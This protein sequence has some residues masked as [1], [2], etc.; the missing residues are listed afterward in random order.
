MP[1][2]RSSDEWRQV[3]AE[4]ED[5]ERRS[6]P[7]VMV[8]RKPRKLRPNGWCL[9]EQCRGWIPYSAGAIQRRYLDREPE[10]DGEGFWE[11]EDEPLPDADWVYLKCAWCGNGK[12][13]RDGKAAIRGD[14]LLAWV[15]R[16]LATPLEVTVIEREAMLP[17]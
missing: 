3:E 7:P 10:W 14:R 8:A 5:Q 4:F 11:D 17:I 1:I 16:Q 2:Y 15:D 13:A 9:G 6:G 12:P